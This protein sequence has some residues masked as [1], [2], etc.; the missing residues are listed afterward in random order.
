MSLSFIFP[1]QASQYV[2]MGKDLFNKFPI[3]QE[4]YQAAKEIVGYDLQ[5]F[6]FE[7]PEEELKQTYITQPAI[8]VHSSIV[9]RLLNEKNIKP[10]FVAGHS[11]GEYSALVACGAFSYEEGLELVKLRGQLMQNAGTIQPGTMAA[12]MGLSPE[13]AVEICKIASEEGIVVP[14]NFNS[15]G[16][17]AISGSIAGITKAVEL[18]KEAGAKRAIELVVSGA[19]HSP[20]MET[21]TEE[22]TEALNQ[23]EIKEP[24]CPIIPNVTAKP[25]RDPNEIRKNLINQLTNPVLWV[26]SMET[27][28]GKGITDFYE[29]GPGRVLSG[30]LKRIDRSVICKAVDKVEDLD[31]LN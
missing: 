11:L 12:I 15:P 4:M 10:A 29:V 8:F 17:I 2:G 18:A 20:L 26:D 25:T 14:A 5:K 23:I 31:S 1:G 19:F 9:F 6:S 24:I 16:Q 30:L 21:A 7:G 27:I 28:I 13:K 3:A 22:M